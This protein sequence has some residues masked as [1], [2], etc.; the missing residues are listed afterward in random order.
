MKELRILIVDDQKNIRDE[1]GR[2]LRDMGYMYLEYAADGAEAYAKIQQKCEMRVPYQLILA[3]CNMPKTSGL[4][5]LQMIRNFRA[6]PEQNTAFQ[7]M[8]NIPFIMVTTESDNDT[9]VS[10]IQS[11]ADN[12]ILKPF[13]KEIVEDRIT[14]LEKKKR[15]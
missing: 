11:G 8:H 4:E 2:V 9:V 6:N 7:S 10:A 1:N 3:D 5:L 13:T 12:Y 14:F 15:I